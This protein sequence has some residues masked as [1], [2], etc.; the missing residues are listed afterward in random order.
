M[1]EKYVGNPITKDLLNRKL[2]GVCAGIAQ[3][4]N[5]RIIS[6]RA[7]TVVLGLFFPVPT[8]LAY[9]LAAFLMPTSRY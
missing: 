7:I 8:I 4:Y 1:K 2:S 6:V 9:L 3:Y 5:M